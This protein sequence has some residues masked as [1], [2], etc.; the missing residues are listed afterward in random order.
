MFYL[1]LSH[2]NKDDSSALHRKL[3]PPVIAEKLE[4]FGSRSF[5]GDEDEQI[6][7]AAFRT[8]IVEMER[9]VV[10]AREHLR[11]LPPEQTPALT[12]EVARWNEDAAYGVET[13]GLEEISPGLK[14]VQ[15]SLPFP[16]SVVIVK[17]DGKQKMWAIFPNVH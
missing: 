2:I 11:R 13:G 9:T 7:L 4:A 12:R 17:V 16:F 6:D 14:A 3:F 5:F 1:L 10:A 8:H 15:V